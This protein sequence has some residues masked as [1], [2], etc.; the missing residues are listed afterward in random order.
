MYVPYDETRVIAHLVQTDGEVVGVCRG[1]RE[2]VAR[3]GVS[4]R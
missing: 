3:A 4:G 1:E 2:G